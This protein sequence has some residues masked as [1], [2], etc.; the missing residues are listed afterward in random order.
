MKKII[1]A[2]GVAVLLLAALPVTTFAG[3]H[4]KGHHRGTQ[5]V[6]YPVC[7]T[8]SCILAEL[9]THNNKTYAAHYYGDG[10]DYHRS[11][12]GGGRHH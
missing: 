4:G 11:N 3:G 9:H 7:S 10:H 1:A 5:T 6:K 2:L 12:H 8:K